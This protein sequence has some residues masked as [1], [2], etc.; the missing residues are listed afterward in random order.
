MGSCL[1]WYGFHH[2]W[3]L[4]YL[5]RTLAADSVFVDVGANQGEFSLFAAKYLR[6]GSVL[7]VEPEAEMFAT[8]VKNIELNGFRNIRPLN[9][10]LGDSAGES[11]LYTSDDTDL[12]G[13]WHEGLF[14]AFPSQYRNKFVQS[15]VRK[16]LDD[17]LASERM[18]RV[19]FVKID[20]E[21]AELQVLQGARET[22]RHLKPQL[23]L[24]L[25]G[26][27]S[28][29]AGYS[30]AEVVEFLRMLDYDFW[31]IGRAGRIDVM[32]PQTACEASCSMNALCTP[33]SEN[34]S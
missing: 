9:I 12:M 23:L 33:S 2:R 13:G 22:L 6:H 1:Y 3:E 5:R 29:Q 26:E 21:G 24:E 7:A 32:D 16:R 10:A 31:S 15:C 11:Q 19:D 28:R 8:L 30:V 14:T 27:T 25:N 18:T 34:A 20:V 17:V 4:S